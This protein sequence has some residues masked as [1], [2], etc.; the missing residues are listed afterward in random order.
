MKKVFLKM[1]SSELNFPEMQ[2]TTLSIEGRL[3]F[4]FRT[5]K[6]AVD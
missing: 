5:F 3:D 1:D 6:E 4:K 2:L